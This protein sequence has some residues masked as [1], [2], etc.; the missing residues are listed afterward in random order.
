M[1]LGK[2]QTFSLDSLCEAIF[3]GPHATPEKTQEGPIYLGISNLANGR[4][5]LSD[6]EYLSEE[7]FIKWTRRVTPQPN[8][9]VFSYET[10]L[11]EA[12][13]IPHGLRCCLGRRM[14]LMRFDITKVDPQFM[15]YAYLGPEFQ[16]TIRARTIHG[17]TVDRIPL[18]QLPDFPITI[19]DLPTQRRIADILSSLDDKIDLNRQTNATLEAMAQAIFQEWF[20]NFNYPGATG[21]MVESELGL[22]PKGWRVY[23]LADLVESVSITH[24]FKNDRIIFLNTSDIENGKVLTHEY[25]SIKGLPGQAKKSI[26][27]LDILFTEIRPGNRRFALIDFDAD[28]YVVST[29]LMVLRTKAQV[30]PIVIYNF[31]TS[32]EILSHLQMLAESRSGTFPQITFD[33]VKELQIVLPADQLL[34]TYTSL[35]WSIFRKIKCNEG[36]NSNLDQIRDTLLPKLMRGEIEV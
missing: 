17:S 10:R 13:L 5:D 15:L 8:D 35:V 22:I 28:D 12:A 24:K 19:P 21:E 2:W 27:K 25:R 3:D 9:L 4:I 16:Q 33:Q 31:L 11:G 23:K 34:E 6:T 32:D 30:A 18:I 29:K 7:D 14:G 1:N 26:Q 36:E 20:V